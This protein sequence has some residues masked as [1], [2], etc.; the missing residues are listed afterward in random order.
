M[1]LCEEFRAYAA[2]IFMACIKKPNQKL[3]ADEKYLRQATIITITKSSCWVR[4][5]WV[6][7]VKWAPLLDC[8]RVNLGSS[9]ALP[10]SCECENR[11][12]H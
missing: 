5:G 9:G 3:V 10:A 12:H 11:N 2:I 1:A 4:F 7:V 8:D 6:V